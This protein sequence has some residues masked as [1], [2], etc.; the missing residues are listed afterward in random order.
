MQARVE[1]P[2][3]AFCWHGGIPVPLKEIQKK[4]R[5]LQNISVRSADTQSPNDVKYI[6]NLCIKKKIVIQATKSK[7][8][9]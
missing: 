4:V 9:N 8:I 2:Q 6:T 3:E 5:S 7:K 1:K